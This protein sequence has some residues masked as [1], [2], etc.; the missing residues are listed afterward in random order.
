MLSINYWNILQ[1]V[2]KMYLLQVHCDCLEP[3]SVLSDGNLY[4][5]HKSGGG[6]R[7]AYEI[8]RDMEV[9]IKRII[10]WFGFDRLRD[11][12]DSQISGFCYWENIWGFCWQEIRGKNLK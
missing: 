4:S 10:H 3:R 8:E 12:T 2:C 9:K 6:W 11:Q 7:K 1:K 5:G